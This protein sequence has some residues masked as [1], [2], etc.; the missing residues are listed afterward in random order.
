MKKIIF[1]A[2]SVL[3]CSTTLAQTEPL[4]KYLRFTPSNLN[5]NNIN[6]SDIPSEQVLRQMGLSEDEVQ[7]AMNFKFKRGKYD[8]NQVD[9]SA[10]DTRKN[11]AA[12]FYKSLGDSLYLMDSIKYPVGK[13]FGQDFF[14]NRNLFF[15]N[16]AHDAKAPDNYLLGEGDELTISIWGMADYS[17]SLVVNEKGFISTSRA[18]RVYVGGKNFKT[19]KSLI[20]NKMG[21][22]YDLSR[23]QLD[24]TL[25]YSRVITVNII[26]EVF[27]P[28]SYTIPATN[29]AF[30]ALLAAGGPS[31]IGSVRNIYLRRGGKTVDSLDVYAFLFDSNSSQDLFLQDNDYLYVAPAEKIVEVKGA[32]NRP[33]TYEAK[34]RRCGVRYDSLCRRIYFKSIHKRNSSAQN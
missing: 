20:K 25:N 32:V 14:R 21:N 26:G 18:G 4:K 8:P 19:V 3:L 33:Y 9:S 13:I 30:N 29:T 7:E 22:Y 34:K 15:F 24:V 23:S 27:N 31:Q 1:I 16:K 2:L 11:Q 6:P 10:F 5:Q 28:G 12:D 17:E